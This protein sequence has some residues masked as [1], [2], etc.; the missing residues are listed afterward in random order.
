MKKSLKRLS[1][2][3][4]MIMMLINMMPVSAFA[5][6]GTIKLGNTA[7]VVTSIPV[8]YSAPANGTDDYYYD[9]VITLTA[10]NVGDD[11]IFQWQQSSDGTT[12]SN[13]SGATGKTYSFTVNDVTFA[14]SYRV[15][16]SGSADSEPVVSAEAKP[17]ADH[18]VHAKLNG[19]PQTIPND[20]DHIKNANLSS[21]VTFHP[22]NSQV[23][24]SANLSFTMSYQIKDGEL[25]AADHALYNV[26]TIPMS[27]FGIVNWTV[28]DSGTI[29]SKDSNGNTVESGTYTAKN[30]V[31]TFNYSQSFMDQ[32]YCNTSGILGNF[33]ISGTLG[34]QS[35]ST[36]DRVIVKIGE[37]T[38][39]YYPNGVGDMTVEKRVA[40]ADPV[41]G[42][43]TWEVKVKSTTG[44]FGDYKIGDESYGI[45]LTD[46]ITVNADDTRITGITAENGLVD[47][48]KNSDTQYTV[49]LE[50]LPAN[51]VWVV[52]V[53]T[54]NSSTTAEGLTEKTTNKAKAESKSKIGDLKKEVTADA[55]FSSS[56]ILNKGVVI[57]ETPNELKDTIG[58]GRVAKWT[59]TVNSTT[60]KTNLAGL[61]LTDEDMAIFAESPNDIYDVD[62]IPSNGFDPLADGKSITFTATEN[63][64]NLNQYTITFYTKLKY[65]STDK[66]YYDKNKA[67]LK[68]GDNNVFV[69]EAFYDY[70]LSRV[71][72]MEKKATLDRANGKAY[73]ELTINKDRWPLPDDVSISD[74]WTGDITDQNPNGLPPGFRYEA[75]SGKVY[76]NDSATAMDLTVSDSSSFSN[77]IAAVNGAGLSGSKKY[78]VKYTFNISDDASGN[79][80]NVA[81]LNETFRGEAGVGVSS[82]TIYNGTKAGTFDGQNDRFKWTIT[83][84]DFHYKMNNWK[85]KDDKLTNGSTFL[86]GTPVTIEVKNA[87][88]KVVETVTGLYDTMDD[89]LEAVNE[90][91]AD[92]TNS[93][94]V[95]YYSSIEN[96]DSVT[97]TVDAYKGTDKV[98]PNGVT[99]ENAASLQ[100]TVPVGVSLAAAKKYVS[101]EEIGNGVRK[102]NWTA[103]YGVGYNGAPGMDFDIPNTNNKRAYAYILEQ[104]QNGQYFKKS[105]LDNLN[106]DALFGEGNW[107]IDYDH[108]T[109][110]SGHENCYTNL[111][112]NYWHVNKNAF[113]K[114]ISYIT[115]I[116]NADFEAADGGIIKNQTTISVKEGKTPATATATFATKNKVS[117]TKALNKEV[118]SGPDG[119]AYGDR[120]IYTITANFGTADDV[121]SY[122]SSV[123]PVITDKLPDHVVPVKVA[124]QEIKQN[125]NGSTYLDGRWEAPFVNNT[126]NPHASNYPFVYDPVNQTVTMTSNLLC[127]P[128]NGSN[129]KQWNI[130]GLIITIYAKVTDDFVY[131]EDGTASIINAADVKI[132]NTQ[133]AN[134]SITHTV[135]R[136][137][138]EDLIK[139]GG[140]LKAGSINTVEYT[141]TLNPD[142]KKL[143][144]VG[145]DETFIEVVDTL[146]WRNNDFPLS[147][148]TLREGSL[149]LINLKTGLPLN[150]SS[151]TSFKES[152]GKKERIIKLSIPDATPVQMTY[153]YDIV[154]TKETNI[155]LENT[156][157]LNGVTYVDSGSDDKNYHV[158]KNSAAS[159]S[160]GLISFTKIKQGAEHVLLQGAEFELREYTS[161]SAY[162]TVATAVSQ[163][164]GK[165]K[166]YANGTQDDFEFKTDT[167][168]E[169][170]ETKA[171][172][173]YHII[174]A[175]KAYKFCIGENKVG[176]SGVF[177]HG[178]GASVKRPNAP[179]VKDLVVTKAWANV[180]GQNVKYPDNIVITVY[181]D[182]TPVQRKTVN[183]GSDGKWPETVTFEN[184]E[185]WDYAASEA[186]GRLVEAEYTIGENPLQYYVASVQGT[187]ITN[188]Y[189][190][191]TVSG[192]KTWND[193]NN[194]DGKRPTSIEVTLYAGEGAAK[195]KV[196]LEGLTNPVTVRADANGDWKYSFENLPKYKA[197]SNVEIVYSVEE[198][199]IYKQGSTTEL[200]YKPTYTD[201]N[202]NIVNKYT[203]ETI[204]INGTKV[205]NDGNNVNR[206]TSVTIKLFAD[207]NPVLDKN[208]NAVTTTA[209]A[210]DGWSWK[211]E[212]LPKY[213]PGAVGQLV[214]YS[215]EEVPV[216]GYASEVTG[217]AAAG[218]TITNTQ[219]TTVSGSKTWRDDGASTRP[220]GGIKITL[221]S[222]VG[223]AEPSKV[224]A[225]SN[226]EDFQNPV[227]VTANDGWSWRFTNLPKYDEARNEI[228]YSITEDTV[229]GYDEPAVDGYNVTNVVLTEVEATKVWKD[230]SNRDGVRPAKI[231][232]QLMQGV[233][234]EAPA[235][236]ADAPY[237]IPVEVT[238]EGDTWTYTFE[239]LPKYS[240]DGPVY[241]Y[242]V[243]EQADA[244][245]ADGTTAT[246]KAL[247]YK[248]EDPNTPSL[249]VTNTREVAK[250]TVSGE[251]TWNDF[252]DQDRIRPENITVNLKADGKK[253]E[254]KTATVTPDEDGKWAYTFKDLPKYRD[255]G[256]EIAYSVEESPI[257]KQGS[258]TELLYTP[259]YTG[260]NIVNTYRPETVDIQ[261]AKTW[262]D[263]QPADAERAAIEITLYAGEGEAKTKVVKDQ[264]GNDVINPVTVDAEDNWKYE[265][266]NLPK[267]A[268]GVEI[269]YSIEE[270]AITGYETDINGYD[271][272]NTLLTSVS[273]VK[274]WIDGGAAD[275]KRPES[276]TIKLL[277]D[278][279]Q[280]K[281]VDGNDCIK[282][283]TADDDWS[284]TFTKLPVYASADASD[285]IVYTVEETVVPTGYK[286]SYQGTA[287]DGYTIVNTLQTEVPVE[288]KWADG[289]VN[290]ANTAVTVQ[291]MQDGVEYG[292]PVSLNDANNWKH[293]FTDLPMYKSE[294]VAYKYEVKETNVPSGYEVTY[295]GDAAEGYTV[296]N[297]LLTDIPVEKVWDDEDNQDALRPNKIGIDLKLYRKV[298][299][300]KEFVE[301]VHLD[302]N[303]V[304]EP[305]LNSWKHTF[306]NLPK[307]DLEGNLYTY[308]VE[309][310]EGSYLEGYIKTEDGLTVTN[311]H[312]PAMVDLS[313]EKTWVDE[314]NEDQRPAQITITLYG[315]GAV[316]TEDELEQPVNPIVIQRADFET[317]SWSFTNLPKYKNVDGKAVEIQYEVKETLPDGTEYTIAYSNAR[318][319]GSFVSDVTNTIE[320]KYLE[321]AGKKIWQKDGYTEAYTVPAIDIQLLRDGEVIATYPLA[322]VEIAKGVE[323]KELTYKFEHLPMYAV[324]CTE[325]ASYEGDMDGH[326]FVYTVKEVLPESHETEDKKVFTS[327]EAENK[328]NGLDFTNTLK[329][330]DVKGTKTWIYYGDQELTELYPELTIQLYANGKLVEAHTQ[331]LKV[332]DTAYAIE[333]LPEYDKDGNKIEYTVKEVVEAKY[334][335]GFFSPDGV[336]NATLGKDFINTLKTVNV[337]GKK[338]WDGN[339][340]TITEV[341]TIKIELLRNGTVIDT[342]TLENGDTTY[343]FNNLPKYAVPCDALKNLPADELTGKEFTYTVRE[344]IVVENEDV[345]FDANSVKT[346]PETKDGSFTEDFTNKILTTSVSG[347]KTWN[348]N[349]NSVTH[350]DVVIELY[351]DKEEK[352]I[353]TRTLKHGEENYIFEDLPL[354][355]V[356]KTADANGYTG[357]TGAID[358]HK[359]EYTV[360]E[361]VPHG[362]T[363]VQTNT[364][365]TNT[366][367]VVEVKGTKTWIDLGNEDQR[368]ETITI[369]LMRDGKEY[370]DVVIEI[371]EADKTY[372]YSFAD[373][374]KYAIAG[375]ADAME[376]D[377]LDGHEFEYTVTENVVTDYDAAI[378]GYDVTNTIS[379]KFTEL[380]GKKTWIDG[381]DEAEKRPASIIIRLYRDGEQI[382]VA[383]VTEETGW[384]WKF[385]KLAV[386]GV[387]VEDKGNYTYEDADGHTF[388]YTV[389]EDAVADYTTIQ[390][391]NSFTNTIEQ[392]YTDVIGDKTWIDFE[393]EDGKRPETITI[394]LLRD[395]V[396]IDEVTVGEAEGWHW[397]FKDLP[398]YAVEPI[399]GKPVVYPYEARDGHTFKY[400]VT[401]DEVDQYTTEV[402]GFDVENTLV[403]EYV[404]VSGAKTWVDPT[405]TVHDPI[406]INLLRDGV[407]IDEIVLNNGVVTYTFDTLPKYAVPCDDLAEE[408]NYPYTGAMDGHIFTYT[409][410]EDL[411]P[412][413]TTVQ[414]GTN[415][416]NTI[417]QD[418]IPVTITKIWMDNGAVGVEHPTIT[419]RLLRNGTEIASATLADGVTSHTFTNMLRYN[420][421]TGQPYVYTVTE[422]PVEGYD[423][424]I[425][426]LTITN[427]TQAPEMITVSGTKTWSGDNGREHDNASE[428]KITLTRRVAGGK[429]EVVDAPIVW[430]GAT[431]SFNNLLKEDE[432]GRTYIYTIREDE[433]EGYDAYYQG[434]DINN[435][436]RYDVVTVNVAGT[437][438][439]NDNDDAAGIRPEQVVVQLLR[440]GTVIDTVAISAAEN[441]SYS[442]NDLPDNDG[443]GHYY[444]YTVAE[445]LV[446]GYW[447]RVE[448]NDLYN[449]REEFKR[450]RF[451]NFREEELEELLD[452]FDYGVPLW[453]GLLGTGDEIPVYPFAFGGL[454][455]LALVAFLLYNRKRNRT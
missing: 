454:G 438:H 68:N 314:G 224:T 249:T 5:E 80:K 398:V 31:I 120:L 182:G 219:L 376:G 361:V 316:V 388:V 292:K 263:G 140:A 385:E 268:E 66:K 239:N 278:G 405:G 160:T 318:K 200:L 389:T 106:F 244:I 325:L 82:I 341:P 421:T 135:S 20:K 117:I 232:L 334:A 95:T 155:R 350:P 154:S 149:E 423:T 91:T 261:G 299:E 400:T 131:G 293:T 103:T 343:A 43:I 18:G 28:D 39:Y 370:K 220:A 258:D 368:P 69:S 372:D 64:K 37:E 151:E 59:I 84:N 272:T 231:K 279:K 196:E 129:L 351:R 153:A 418:F 348:D 141:V 431:Y 89:V 357:Y 237:N 9:D 429:V 30:G 309:E 3:V 27:E 453:G 259:A 70:S 208:N 137:S 433:V 274:S 38:Y 367:E 342:A 77:F 197:N 312:E 335:E 397:E 288:K 280:A 336:N 166:F 221:M 34:L 85:L 7:R 289:K 158:V 142:G 201:N 217:S 394:N 444:T 112:V 422:D 63:G 110:K 354:Y 223:N 235:P 419:V 395:G 212:D 6:T 73:F 98:L 199:P 139:K 222:K 441:W 378:N 387:D 355:A 178:S 88:N 447:L 130:V 210:G 439:W 245:K 455:L 427:T 315:D 352:A 234:N 145:T 97:N 174:E 358:G 121:V 353:A 323:S 115:Y 349:G 304:V 111:R 24:T 322:S 437:K 277:A 242:T 425:N 440:D 15:L 203:P 311:C 403:Q 133:S 383:T 254:G 143:L 83:V 25:R 369:N 21:N 45:K 393:N 331:T 424:A 204:D 26:W 94:S 136:D 163:A 126:S 295:L 58:E 157:T 255:G 262:V 384:A 298:G 363:S 213:K 230:D 380:E 124:I 169:L 192:I 320:Q 46:T 188:T 377:K 281:N 402:E 53:T 345:A 226:V 297:T 344:V 313:G 16:V 102:I 93:V 72:G 381:D 164:N 233:G 195:E 147:A 171:P 75:G 317:A 175:S 159:V 296:V 415:F 134:T 49:Y 287:A 76:V 306:E 236:Y 22:D 215:V 225:N 435:R 324:P 449:T 448:G 65:N 107:V 11:A 443:Y 248:E 19:A 57:V 284:W 198:T 17:S 390:S 127:G 319:D 48:E 156:V 189:S 270:K 118:Q 138:G 101:H 396:E 100:A 186:A 50:N 327:A 71:P 211:F 99:D 283:V 1:A 125:E 328:T 180:D 330:V 253:V 54:Q 12:W 44:T 275:K 206:P 332:G 379:Q 47:F 307:Y 266:K 432:N 74:S 109:A 62:I 375:L 41:R 399:D 8:T 451:G 267:K 114:Q 409:V 123:G 300:A 276:I 81:V 340:N 104:P 36:Q 430:D 282:T 285:P 356:A 60:P 428:V 436:L 128:A 29:Y 246:L 410:T 417:E 13:I 191:V 302:E 412:G 346:E 414:N 78:T 333:N 144:G 184:L 116:D 294:G 364:D 329:T 241:V 4:L 193:E 152:N 90:R 371:N 338:I 392:K 181:R 183:R 273:A 301:E 52:N 303:N 450:M 216:N 55:Q 305:D 238:G 271:V 172:A 87:D 321:V 35:G 227:T 113:N 23:I 360:K 420:L 33:Q 205:W 218:F 386:Y 240:V 407:E 434:Y 347:K 250:V 170:V 185:K 243:E 391:G 404:E 32:V 366:L 401:E 86:A 442:F 252:D 214:T 413:Y 286:V 260:N 362:Y 187:T 265:F 148:I 122:G 257:Y 194:R 179:D 406:T 96:L 2:I 40:A 339:K 373:L 202:I 291:L 67:V 161:A 416:T 42:S 337:S 365:F 310:Q 168:Y 51:G 61:T 10:G 190:P 56:S 108:M 408:G 290:H 264:D 382:D 256:V 207:G 228:I 165:L 251:K 326:T 229:A 411:V 269:K 14:N 359:F 119:A 167:V 209:T 308:W 150:V 446:P 105:D 445:Q 132:G 176:A 92:G 146:S 374:P 426:G 162:N 79:Y 452:I 247:G 177:H 173:G